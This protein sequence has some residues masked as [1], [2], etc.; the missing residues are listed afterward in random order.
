MLGRVMGEA[1]YGDDITPQRLPPVQQASFVL[2]TFTMSD[3]PPLHCHR[4]SCGGARGS[5]G[6]RP[7]EFKTERSHPARAEPLLRLY[8]PRRLQAGTLAYHS[9]PVLRARCAR[10]SLWELGAMLL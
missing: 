10:P 6:A 4:K 5:A 3:S 7:K 8:V 9:S 1:S 2:V